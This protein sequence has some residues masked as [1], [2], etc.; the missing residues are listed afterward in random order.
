MA[1]VF[2]DNTWALLGC[3]G[4]YALYYRRRYRA[5]ARFGR[6]HVRRALGAGTAGRERPAAAA[7]A[8]TAP[9]TGPAPNDGQD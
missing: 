9:Q 1:V 7:A 2:Y 4:V 3:L 5:L 8:A 6:R